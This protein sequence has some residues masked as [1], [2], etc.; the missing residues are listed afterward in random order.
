MS[1]RSWVCALLSL[2]LC[3]SAQ[4]A[5][6]FSHT[7]DG[8]E[9]SSTFRIA[10]DGNASV[11]ASP[12]AFPGTVLDNPTYFTTTTVSG[13]TPGALIAVIPTSQDSFTFLSA[14]D[15]SFSAS[16]LA[17]NYLADQ[18]AS[19]VTNSFTFFAPA[20]GQFVV[21]GNSVFYSGA[22]AGG[23]SFSAFIVPEPSSVMFLAMGTSACLLGRRSR[24]ASH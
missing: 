23:H 12:K 20:S 4:A 19:S 21:V 6:I 10:R 8:S 13:A 5:F 9:T 16:S 24:R 17:T 18:G 1:S 11:A 15:T 22:A 2:V 7:F 3:G 14:Y